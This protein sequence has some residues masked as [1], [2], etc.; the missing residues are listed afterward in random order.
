MVEFDIFFFISELCV[1]SDK[2][3]YEVEYC[4]VQKF[5]IFRQ[6]NNDRPQLHVT[7]IAENETRVVLDVSVYSGQAE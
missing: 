7:R 4:P 6:L 3:V 2:V 1:K 5:S